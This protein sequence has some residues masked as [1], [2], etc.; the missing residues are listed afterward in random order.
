MRRIDRETRS[1]LTAAFEGVNREF[2][3][4]FARMFGGGEA[5]LELTGESALDG[6]FEIKARPPGKRQSPVRAL[7]GGEKAAAALAF[8]IAVM[9]LNPPPF[10]LLDEVDA[11]L[12][13]SRTERLAGILTDIGESVQCVVVTH[14]KGTM[15]AMGR[16]IGVTQEEPGVSRIVSVSVAEAARYAA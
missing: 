1:R 6:E 11:P 15:E 16:L 2:P 14:N 4:L 12:D 10:C 5:R 8:I 7:S 13:D 3:G 9:R